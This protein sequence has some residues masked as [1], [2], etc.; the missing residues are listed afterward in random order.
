M[1]YKAKYLSSAVQ[2]VSLNKTLE[3]A[4]TD[5]NLGGGGKFNSDL[6]FNGTD[7]TKDVD[8]SSTITDARNARWILKD[9]ANDFEQL[10]ISIKTTS[11]S[12]VRITVVPALPSG[13]YR[14]LGQE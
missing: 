12:N 8:V 13:T 7:T 2:M 3:Q 6:S 5:G 10:V 14:L 11:A 4:Y 9:N 1:A